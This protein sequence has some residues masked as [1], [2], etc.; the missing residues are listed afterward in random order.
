MPP[1]LPAMRLA[2]QLLRLRQP[3]LRRPYSTA[4]PPNPSPVQTRS[5]R[6]P[7]IAGGLA[8]TAGAGFYVLSRSSAAEVQSS[9]TSSANENRELTASAAR[10]AGDKEGKA[11]TSANKAGGS[12]QD[13]K[14]A[15]GVADE[16]PESG[17][18]G[19]SRTGKLEGGHDESGL[20]KD[21][22]I[23]KAKAGGKS[24]EKKESTD[25][26][27]DGESEGPDEGGEEPQ[28]AVGTAAAF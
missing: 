9:K 5:L 17:A 14:A 25:E 13:P 11:E 1:R 6:I 19:D 23:R 20:A 8:L 22:R 2:P 28:G 27:K 24:D 3:R 16:K 7:L 4:P 18:S 12:P 21:E 10:K 26:K 15:R